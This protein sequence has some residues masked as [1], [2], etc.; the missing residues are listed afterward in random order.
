MTL[1]EELDT[2]IDK[3]KVDVSYVGR[4]ESFKIEILALFE[5]KLNEAVPEYPLS[6]CVSVAEVRIRRDVVTDMQQNIK[7]VLEGK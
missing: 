6:V 3:H 5:R 4:L 2:I 7:K 1:T